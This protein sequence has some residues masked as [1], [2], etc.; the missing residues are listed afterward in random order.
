MYVSGFVDVEFATEPITL[1]HVHGRS[2]IICRYRNYICQLL[3]IGVPRC[4]K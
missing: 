4:D 2:A 1:L 3:E